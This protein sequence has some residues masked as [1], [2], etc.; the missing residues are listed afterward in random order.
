LAIEEQ[1]YL[2]W[3]LAFLLLRT[4]KRRLQALMIIIPLVWI[5][6]TVGVL[7]FHVWQG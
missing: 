5:Y 2:L 3:P 1:F 6:R 7:G 4:P